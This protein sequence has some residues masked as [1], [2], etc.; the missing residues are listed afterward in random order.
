[1][2]N[3]TLT[4]RMGIKKKFLY[5]KLGQALANAIRKLLFIKR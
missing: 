4:A 3:I 2:T 5:K 1:M